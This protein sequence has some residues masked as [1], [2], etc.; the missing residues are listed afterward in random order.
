MPDA[1]RA[2]HPLFDQSDIAALVQQTGASY[3]VVR[4]AYCEEMAALR[5][6]AKVEKFLC[7]IASRR[8]RHRLKA[9]SAATALPG[10]PWTAA[11]AASAAAVN[12]RSSPRGVTARRREAGLRAER[13]LVTTRVDRTDAT[14]DTISETGV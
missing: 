4:Q 2:K 5:S 12:L 10:L 14:G 9:K 13:V 1:M 7:I 8:V 3:E 6:G 11:P